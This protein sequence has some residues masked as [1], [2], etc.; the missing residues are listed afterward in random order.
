MPRFARS[1][2]AFVEIFEIDKFLVK[3]AA[4]S[5]EET[6]SISDETWL[7]KISKL[8]REECDRAAPGFA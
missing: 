3:V 8:S 2:N 4:K 1:L 5:S 6:A 7:N